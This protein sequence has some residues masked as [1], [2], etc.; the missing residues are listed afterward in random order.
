MPSFHLDHSFT[1][2]NLGFQCYLFGDEAKKR[3]SRQSLHS[4]ALPLNT[5]GLPTLALFPSSSIFFSGTITLSSPS[6][7]SLVNFAFHHSHFFG[8][9]RHCWC[10]WRS[11]ARKKTMAAYEGEEKMLGVCTM[12]R[13]NDERKRIK[14]EYMIL[15]GAGRKIGV[16][17]EEDRSNPFS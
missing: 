3:S 4:T 14:F 7:F 13:E 9:L 16:Q 1:C 15:G 10:E 8:S 5:P 17:E 12:N 2:H 6:R 11:T